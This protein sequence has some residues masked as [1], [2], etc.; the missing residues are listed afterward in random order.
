MNTAKR[1]EGSATSRTLMVAS[2]VLAAGAAA[3]S[4]SSTPQAVVHR[5]SGA[6]SAS[7]SVACQSQG[8]GT[9]LAAG[10]YHSSQFRPQLIYQVPT[11]WQLFD[12]SPGTFLLLPPG[13]PPPGNTITSGFISVATSVAAEQGCRGQQ[14]PGVGTSVSAIAAH[15][16]GEPGLITTKPMRA[17]I[18]GLTG[19]SINIKMAPGAKGCRP[20]ESST[21]A[22]PLLV[23]LGQSQ[24]DHEIGRGVAERDYLLSYS[25]GTLAIEVIDVTGGTRL[26]AYNKIVRAF[27][28]TT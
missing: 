28:F 4:S 18:G 12:D 14:A 3:C 10:I 21:T 25:G 1:R 27:R 22:V 2:L 20:L 15:I 19:V 17:R 8:S 11:G 26:A 13:A 7:K 9:C 24:F 6:P 5:P 16:A 23:G